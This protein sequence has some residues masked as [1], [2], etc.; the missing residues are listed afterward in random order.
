MREAIFQK[1][2]ESIT[3]N[4][5]IPVEDITI[6]SS[7]EELG[8]D[9]LDS[10]SVIHNLENTY[11]ITLSNENALKIKTVLDAVEVLEKF[12]GQNQLYAKEKGG[13]NG[14]GNYFQHR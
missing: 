14:H 3:A 12:V 8:M 9:S 7:F 10:L 4:T 6:N 11:D 1:I 5:N 13:D 2:V